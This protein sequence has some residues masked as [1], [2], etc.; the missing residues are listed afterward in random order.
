MF[1]QKQKQKKIIKCKGQEKS[2]HF[3]F[4]FN[5]AKEENKKR[6]QKESKNNKIV[7]CVCIKIHQSIKLSF[8][9]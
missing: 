2:F 4:F 1:P 9:E 3:F 5:H 8:S 7:F 6:I